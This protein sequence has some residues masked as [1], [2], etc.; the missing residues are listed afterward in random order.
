M[1]IA[2]LSIGRHPD[3]PLFIAANRDEY[4]ARASCTAAPWPQAS[5]VIAGTDLVG[6]GTWLGVTRSGRFGFLT[7]YRDPATTIANAPSRGQLVSH[8]LAGG[9]TPQDYV[10]A[11]FK[12][13]ARF[14]GFNLIVGDL[15]QTWYTG[16]R[17]P[18]NAPL[19][20]QAKS[21]TLSNHLL[22]TPW[23][24][25]I[26]LRQALDKFPLS[27]LEKS[28]DT[29]FKLLHD[30]TPAADADLPTTGVPLDKER[31]LGSPFII[32][33]DYGT[34]CST[35]VAINANGWGFLAEV[36][37]NPDGDIV[38]RHDWPFSIFHH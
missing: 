29:V 28:T 2:Y 35:I 17:T 3:W 23:P 15:S 20:L 26:L 14:N 4:H 11:I 24:K 38:E 6:G 5:C 25:T 30:T 31:L 16:N 12:E 22:D 36:T 13:Q 8:Y 32:S 34:R 7:N 19:Q 27:S 33:P 21:Y 10:N 18:A 37:Y 9:A 1:C